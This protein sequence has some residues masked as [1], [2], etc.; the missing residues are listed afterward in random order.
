MSMYDDMDEDLSRSGAKFTVFAAIAIVSLV[1][2]ALLFTPL[3]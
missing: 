2:V 3:P 1:A